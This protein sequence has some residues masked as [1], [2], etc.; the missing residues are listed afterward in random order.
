MVDQIDN[1]SDFLR[2]AKTVRRWYWG[3]NILFF[4][5][6][7]AVCE[8]SLK[9]TQSVDNVPYFFFAYGA[10]MAIASFKLWG[11]I[12]A[13]CGEKFFDANIFKGRL[14]PYSSECTHCGLKIK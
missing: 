4:P 6:M 11:L 7:T 14:G 3:I 10:L 12:C 1:Y 13:R 2:K 5:Y 8:L 9:L